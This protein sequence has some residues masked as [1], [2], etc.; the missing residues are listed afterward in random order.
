MVLV[1]INM[2]STTVMATSRWS[3]P[4]QGGAEAAI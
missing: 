2:D 4:D 3:T 1:A